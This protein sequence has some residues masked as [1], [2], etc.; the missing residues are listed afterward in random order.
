M[1][2]I[3]R[4]ITINVFGEVGIRQI[5]SMKIILSYLISLQK[6]SFYI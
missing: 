6:E 4:V 2:R 3:A 5:V 1:C